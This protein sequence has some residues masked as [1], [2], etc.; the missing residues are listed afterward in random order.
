MLAL[1]VTR[2]AA[3]AAALGLAALACGF[4]LVRSFWRVDV[5]ADALTE[6]SVVGRTTIPWIGV[7][8]LETTGE[9]LLVWPRVGHPVALDLSSLDPSDRAPLERTVARRVREAAVR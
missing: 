1:V 7:S 9:R 8:R 6:R 5:T 3:R 4:G 2:R